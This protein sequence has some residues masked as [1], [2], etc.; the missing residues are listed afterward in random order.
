MIGSLSSRVLVD[1]SPVYYGWIV[2]AVGTLGLIATSPGQS[3]TVSLFFDFFIEDFGLDRT[4]VSTLYGLGTFMASLSLTWVGKNIDRRGNRQM[5]VIISALFALALAGMSLI[6]GPFMLFIGFLAIR[7]LGQG[8]L[9]LANSTAIAQWF[10]T[11]R[12]RMMSLATIGFAIFQALY[13]PWLQRMLELYDWRQVWIMLA[14]GVAGIALPIILIFMRN[15]P[16][17]FGLV[18]DGRKVVEKRNI[19]YQTD[20]NWTLQQVRRTL[21]F[22]VYTG[23]RILLPAWGTGIIIHQVSLF[24]SLGYQASVAAETYSMLAI[25]MAVF[26]F[27]AGYLVDQIKPGLVMLLH[28]I[29]FMA[30]MWLAMNMTVDWMRY[31][32]AICFAMSMAIG[33]VF[34]GAVWAN[35][36]GRE[37]LGAIRGFIVTLF[38]ASSAAGP[39]FFGWS[40]DNLGGYDPVLWLGIILAAIAGIAGYW[41]K[42]P[43]LPV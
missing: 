15:K 24:E 12:G 29:A 42:K 6:T 20:E 13:V 22:W 38:V 32:F 31:L 11:R 16:E 35:L 1:R 14:L 7:G 43:Q 37:H 40:Y 17:D 41:V 33:G 23:G 34:D 28:L 30:A 3:F 27:G 39:V 36:F 4:T 25:L 5:G 19:V 18:P 21:I 10:H 8:S 2:W 9:G 26:S